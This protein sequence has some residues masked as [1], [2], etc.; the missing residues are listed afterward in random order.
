VIQKKVH[1]IITARKTSGSIPIEASQ[2][3]DEV[4]KTVATQNRNEKE[5]DETQM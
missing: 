1:P 5:V 4:K 2:R 3:Q